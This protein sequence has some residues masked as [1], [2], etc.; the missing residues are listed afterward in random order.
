MEGK[1][2][3]SPCEP[4]L[5]EKNRERNLAKLT[6]SSAK[7]GI[8]EWSTWVDLHNLLHRLQ[9]LFERACPGSK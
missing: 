4:E 8:C 1:S 5:L 3:P 6:V 7:P 2:R 9:W